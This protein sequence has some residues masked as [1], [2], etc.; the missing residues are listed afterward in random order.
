MGIVALLRRPR[1][2]WWAWG[3]FSALWLVLHFLNHPKMLDLAV[4]RAEGEALRHGLGLY[5]N[6]GAPFDL[7]GT[8]PP[9]ATM[10]FVALTLV[11]LTACYV[12]AGVANLVLVVV[13]VALARRLIGPERV[14][15]EFVP[16]LSAALIWAE[17]VYLTLHYGQINLLLL[18][19]VLADVAAP[20]TARFRGVG[21]G[22]AAAIKVTPALFVVYLLLTR[23]F[24]FAGTAAATAAAATLVSAAVRP[25]E[26]WRFWTDLVFHTNRVGNV[27]SPENQSLRGVLARALGRMEP[28]TVG[29]IVTAAA[30]VAGL[31]VAV[32]CYRRLGEPWG[33]CAAAVT[34]LLVSP[35]SWSHH[36]VWCIPIAVMIV[37]ALRAHAPGA[38]WA[39][40]AFAATFA[41]YSFW[42][43]KS[44]PQAN[45]HMNPVDQL[46]SL[47]Y[48]LFGV[49]FLAV[50]GAVAGRHEEVRRP[51][52]AAARG[53]VQYGPSTGSFGRT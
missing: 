26:T 39:A 9:F 42:F 50:A 45:L 2:A 24:R 15:A 40:T 17:P 5:G 11:P 28:G 18:V 46:R 6:I 14:P 32:A 22:L 12:L 53:E 34:G 20:P 23:R 27:A 33:V 21:V 29:A 25:S 3:A 1:V 13:A 8:Y 41:S 38:R 51:L 43:F 7:Q 35:V 31:A 36:W 10:V 19:L 52:A 48:A 49:A 30:L 37:A 47:P 4:Y 16:L 44:D